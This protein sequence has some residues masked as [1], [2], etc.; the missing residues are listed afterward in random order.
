M[1]SSFCKTEARD[2]YVPAV[3]PENQLNAVTMD[4]KSVEGSY[5]EACTAADS[6]GKIGHLYHN[7]YSAK[8]VNFYNGGCDGY[9][10]NW[11]KSASPQASP[12]YSGSAHNLNQQQ[13][14][15]PSP[16]DYQCHEL[17][18]HHQYNFETQ[19]VPELSVN[20]SAECGYSANNYHL[21]N[22][23]PSAPTYEQSDAIFDISS[24]TT[25]SENQ[26]KEIGNLNASFSSDKEVAEEISYSGYSDGHAEKSPT[27]QLHPCA[28]RSEASKDVESA[29]V[30]N[31]GYSRSDTAPKTSPPTVPLKSNRQAGSSNRKER[32]AFTK[33]QVKALEA[34]F[35]HSNYLTRL[36]RYEIA[37]A[38]YLSER[39][40]KVWF[41]NRRM[42]WKRIKTGCSQVT[43][44]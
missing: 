32:T 8:Q 1:Y 5:Y 44:K 41:Q 31:I 11:I 42:K 12:G 17:S 9:N 28:Y 6:L 33:S 4:S 37:V 43:T 39:Q 24:S 7:F 20:E 22:G 35:A 40:V 38:L 10:S 27:D 19:C 29:P 25:N 13:E 14:F 16:E 15:I 30:E 3:P 36:R 23:V 26:E 21:L 2:H 18:F 34:E